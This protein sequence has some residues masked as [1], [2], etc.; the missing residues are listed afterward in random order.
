MTMETLEYRVGEVEKRQERIETVLDRI[1][2][3]LT[4]QTK[5]MDRQ[6]EDRESLRR[7]FRAIEKM[8]ER[9]DYIEKGISENERRR[10]QETIKT[11]GDALQSAIKSRNSM[12]YEILRTIAIVL[13]AIAGVHFGLHII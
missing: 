13:L 4:R 7:C 8:D 6:D 1:S 5:I 2:E 9:M 3:D 10:L 12:I 11:Q